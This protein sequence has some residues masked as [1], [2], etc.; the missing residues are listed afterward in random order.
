MT[1][2]HDFSEYVLSDT[3]IWL[4]K[5]YVLFLYKIMIYSITVSQ[6]RTYLIIKIMFTTW[7]DACTDP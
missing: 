1:G 4:P 3:S 7:D 2:N 6:Q 5:K